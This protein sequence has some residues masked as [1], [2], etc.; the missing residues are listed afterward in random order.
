MPE[1]A[2]GTSAVI[3]TFFFCL[4]FYRFTCALF[5]GREPFAIN[6][7]LKVKRIVVEHLGSAEEGDDA[8]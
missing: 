2:N 8:S 6:V 1:W 4:F 5:G 3:G 7:T